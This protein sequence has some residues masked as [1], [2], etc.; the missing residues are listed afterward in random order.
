VTS[1]SVVT[2]SLTE[3]TRPA[4]APHD[5]PFLGAADMVVQNIA[6]QDD[7]IVMF[8]CHIDWNSDLELRLSFI[9]G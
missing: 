1:A 5:F 4:G 8:R 7:G 6:P 9:I 3:V 2:A